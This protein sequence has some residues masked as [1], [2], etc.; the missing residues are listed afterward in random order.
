MNDN[1][2]NEMNNPAPIFVNRIYNSE[3]RKEVLIIWLKEKNSFVT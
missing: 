3:V 1:N 2:N